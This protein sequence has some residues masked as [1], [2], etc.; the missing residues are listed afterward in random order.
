MSHSEIYKIKDCD[1]S[2]TSVDKTLCKNY[3]DV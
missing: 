3:Q 1:F 2:V